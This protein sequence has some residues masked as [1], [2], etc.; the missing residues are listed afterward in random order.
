CCA[1]ETPRPEEPTMALTPST[2]VPLGTPAPD[3][4]LP[5]T[6]GTTVR[7]SDFTGPP[8]LVMF[9][10]NHCPYVQHVR[11]HLAATC[12]EYQQR[13]VAVVAINANDA[14]AY[15]DEGPEKMA[16]EVR[17]AGYTFPYLYDETQEVAKSFRA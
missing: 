14:T 1:P 15:P 17:A 9:L 13:G 12:K 2:M 6:G 5:D 8:L 7:R 4:A 10:C 16:E 3:F 11:G